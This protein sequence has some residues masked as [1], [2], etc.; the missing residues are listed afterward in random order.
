MPLVD[1]HAHLCDEQFSE[2]LDAVLER[3]TRVGIES[4]LNIGTTRSSSEQCVQLSERILNLRAAVGIHPNYCHQATTEDWTKIEE[5]ADSPRVAAIGETGL[6]RYW[7][8]CPWETQLDFFERHIQL[9]HQQALPIVV[10]S[11]DC[12]REMIDFLTATL[13]RYQV[14]GVMHSFVST[15]EVCRAFLD[16]GMYISFAGQLTYKKLSALREVASKVPLDRLLVETDS[17]YLSP[18]PHRSARP[19]EPARVIHTLEML[20]QTKLL[21]AAKMGEITTAN[22]YRLFPRLA[23]GQGLP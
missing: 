5:L 10:H 18:E 19:N 12:D 20:A 11:R 14:S 15:W 4:I 17:P 3:A 7:H 13:P 6:D 23:R 9:A 1:T 2:S 16:L 22:A 8:D 21:T